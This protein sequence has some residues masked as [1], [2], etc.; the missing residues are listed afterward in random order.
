MAFEGVRKGK[1]NKGFRLSEYEETV[2][3]AATSLIKKRNG[4]CR[5]DG[6]T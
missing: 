1:K 2:H 6:A 3:D 4:P 5:R